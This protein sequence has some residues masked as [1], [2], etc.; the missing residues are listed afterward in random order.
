MEQRVISLL[1]WLLGMSSLVHR[2]Q[3]NVGIIS[4]EGPG[5]KA[6]TTCNNAYAGDISHDK[7]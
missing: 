4:W 6:S 1:E 3:S 5:G 2:H 7:C